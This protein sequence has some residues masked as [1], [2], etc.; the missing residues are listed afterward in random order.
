[1]TELY[2][3]RYQAFRTDQG[4]P[5]R[6]TA[7]NVRFTLGYELAATW[8]NLAPEGAWLRLPKGQFRANYREKLEGQGPEKIWA[9]VQRLSDSHGGKPVVLLCFCDLA[10]AGTWCHRQL[11]AEWWEECTQYPV[12]DLQVVSA[13]P[14]RVAVDLPCD[15]DPAEKLF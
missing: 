11:F 3:S 8:K 12:R 13:T 7:G 1:M 15:D 9:D 14:K 10:K 6:T 4:V 5:V 2:T